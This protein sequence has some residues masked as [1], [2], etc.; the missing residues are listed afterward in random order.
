MGGLYLTGRRRQRD[1]AI[2]LQRNILLAIAVVVLGV[3]AVAA[4]RVVG[5]LAPGGGGPGEE[6]ITLASVPDDQ[7]ALGLLYD[8]LEPARTDAPCAGSYQVVTRETCTHG[9]DLAPPGLSVAR[10]VAPVTGPEPKPR[11]PARE[12]GGPPSDAAVIA[13]QNGISLVP[14]R[15]ALVPD[16]APGDAAFVLGAHGV[17]C[18]GN[19]VNGNRVQVLYLYEFGE[20]SR[21]A[22]YLGSFRAWAA[23]VDAIY[24]ASAGETGG[25]RHVR[26]VTTAGCEVDVAEVQVPAGALGTFERSITA[27]RKLGYNRTDRKYLMF[28]DANRYCAI[29]T[30]VNDRRAGLGNR[31]NG[32]PSY[33][34]VDAGCWSAQ[35]AAHELTHNLGGVLRGA[36]NASVAGHCTDDY[37]LMCWRDS[38]ETTV[39]VVCPER[40]HEQRLDCNHD[41]YFHTDPKPGSYLDRSWNVAD[42]QFLFSGDGGPVDPAEPA[43]PIVSAT[44]AAVATPSAAPDPLPQ[45]SGATG[46][47]GPDA[48]PSELPEVPPAAEPSAPASAAAASTGRAEPVRA[49]APSAPPQDR[50]LEARNPTSTSAQLTW[51]AAP[52]GTRYAVEVDGRVIG[53]TIATRARLVGLRPDTAYAVRVLLDTGRRAYTPKVEVRTGPA[54]RPADDTWFVLEN[55]LTGGS[56]DLYG[57]RTADGTPIVL[58]RAEGGMQQQWKLT[59]A[60]AGEYLLFSRA[61]GKCVVPLGNNPAPG[62][63]LVQATCTPD[64]TSQHWSVVPTEHGFSLSTTVGGLVAGAGEQRFGG[65]RL[66]VLQDPD[67]S[68]HQSWAALPG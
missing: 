27:L 19:G 65:T 2:R 58:N 17:G 61:T 44:S 7:P 33:G 5:G 64:D 66:L 53:A 1:S 60:G 10:D 9:P 59:P 41:D 52:I 57:A 48:P 34:R 67:G 14:G 23:G 4:P 16:A 22:D 13:D 20:P 68:R 45:E 51:T 50:I 26:Y 56:A 62:Q 36:P 35:M 31:N 12:A 24:D 47:D 40:G 43:A 49:P 39:S 29:G 32:G 15:P 30:Y 37:D 28:A 21:Y 18:A 11:N 6:R 63:P 3:L 54:A 55:A 25:S 8:G 42:S 38:T 46:P